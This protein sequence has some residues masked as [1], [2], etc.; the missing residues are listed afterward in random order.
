LANEGFA[1]ALIILGVL[2]LLGFYLG[3]RTEVRK[4]KRDEGK[5]I[6]VSTA[7]II[8]VLA[9]IFLSGIIA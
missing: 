4:I 6:L 9:V 7:I 3:P 5:L 1:A 8:F 2:L